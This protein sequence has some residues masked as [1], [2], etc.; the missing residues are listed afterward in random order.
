[1]LGISTCWWDRKSLPGDEIVDDILDLGF[2][3]VE[4]EYRITPS[5]YRQMKPR[6]NQDLGVLSI[7]NFFPKPRAAHVEEGSGDL[8]LLSSTDRDER[9]K[10]VKY[11][12]KTMDSAHELQAEAVVLHLGRV[13]MPNPMAGFEELL[14]AGKTDQNEGCAFLSQQTLMRH[15]RHQKNLDAVLWSLEQLNQEAE[16]RGLFLGI[17]NRYHFHEIP[18]R[19][20]IGIILRE[21]D[22]GNVRYWHDVGHAAV[23]ENLGIC[24]QQELLEAYSEKMIG[25]HIHDVIG[26]DDHYSPG[27][28]EL[29]YG[30]ITPFLKRTTIKI[31]EVHSK[32]GREALLEGIHFIEELIDH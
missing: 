12:V 20:E 9:L 16:R 29:N 7:H 21:F 32:V 28:G 11:T 10:A 3:A 27:Q 6:L 17:E 5:I 8:F 22:G 15:M 1:M 23:Q 24:A 31:F 19:E 14:R 13:D 2:E 30:E 18:N 26:V 4:L 25:M